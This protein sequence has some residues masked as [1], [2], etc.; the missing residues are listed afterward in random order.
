MAHNKLFYTERH[1]SNIT[2][3]KEGFPF[4]TSQVQSTCKNVE[5]LIGN[6]LTSHRI[7]EA[8]MFTSLIL[9]KLSARAE[10]NPIL[11]VEDG[12]YFS[13]K[14]KAEM[15]SLNLKTR[16][17]FLIIEKIEQKKRNSHG[18]SYGT[19]HSY[20]LKRFSVEIRKLFVS[21]SSLLCARP[22]EC[23]NCKSEFL[24]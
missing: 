21:F 20:S 10:L 24:A 6:G 3:E 4:K 23:R 14:V 8:D 9:L 22:K 7:K 15:K 17:L 1:Q 16:C 12:L 19:S 13:K 5:V 11:K 2:A 18:F